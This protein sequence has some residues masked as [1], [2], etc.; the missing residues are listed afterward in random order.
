[1]M[2]NILIVDDSPVMRAFIKRV[3]SISG[4]D[5]GQ[6]FEAGHGKQALELLR[7]HSV[8][9]VLSDINMPEMNGEEFLRAVQ[10]D[11]ALRSI[12][13]VVV[14]T[15]AR[16]DRVEQIMG[17]GARGYITKPFTPERLRA[18]LDRVLE[19]DHA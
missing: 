9:L 18:E 14:S 13:I 15:D 12:P 8:D 4:I 19:A 17:L 6:P 3:L 11:E 10:A 16:L 7:S 5:V 1:M 2:K